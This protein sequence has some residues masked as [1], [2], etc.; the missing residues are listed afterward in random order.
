MLE[1][2]SLQASSWATY[3][4]FQERDMVMIFLSKWTFSML[5]RR[6]NW[7]PRSGIFQVLKKINEIAYVIYLSSDMAMSKIFYES[8]FYSYVSPRG[9]FYPESNSKASLIQV[10]GN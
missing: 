7:N 1:E 4:E 9:S 6:I 3:K 8:N 2:I 5:E 10:G